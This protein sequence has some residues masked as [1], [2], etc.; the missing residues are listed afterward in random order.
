VLAGKGAAGSLTGGTRQKRPS[1]TPRGAT[2]LPHGCGGTASAAT[3]SPLAPLSSFLA[4]V[5]LMAAPAVQDRVHD[6]V[7]LYTAH[8]LMV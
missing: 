1:P 7:T 5:F 3:V 2:M 4:A 6:S 8:S